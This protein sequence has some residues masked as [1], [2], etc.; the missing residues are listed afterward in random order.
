MRTIFGVLVTP[1]GEARKSSKRL[2]LEQYSELIEAGAEH[3]LEKYKV[4]LPPT[5]GEE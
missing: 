5:R 4:P 3:L 2:T 1:M